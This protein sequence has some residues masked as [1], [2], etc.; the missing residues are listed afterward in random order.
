MGNDDEFDPDWTVAPAT[1]L[2]H[3]LELTGLSAVQL[4]G[5]WGERRQFIAL[6]LIREVLDGRP[7]TDEHATCLG[8]VTTVT[9][10]M[11]HQLENKYRRDLGMGRKEVL[12]WTTR[13]T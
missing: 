1:T 8:Q 2:R 10:Q 11:W 5:R 4:A 3:F 13:N 6:K 12:P 7:L 9:A